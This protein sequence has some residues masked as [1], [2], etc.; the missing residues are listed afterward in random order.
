MLQLRMRAKWLE[1]HESDRDFLGKDKRLFLF[2]GK[3]LGSARF[4]KEL[5]PSGKSRRLQLEK[6]QK[7]PTLKIPEKINSIF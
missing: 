4:L 1:D 3:R 6:L 7:T 5:I 2:R